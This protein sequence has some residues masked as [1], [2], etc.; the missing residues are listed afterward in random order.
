MRGSAGKGAFTGNKKTRLAGRVYYYLKDIIC[1][2]LFLFFGS[3]FLIFF[4]FAAFIRF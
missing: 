2:V 3:F 4:V 1:S